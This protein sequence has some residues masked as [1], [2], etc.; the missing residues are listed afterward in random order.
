MA[1]LDHALSMKAKIIGIVGL[2]MGLMLM[3]VVVADRSMNTI[4]AEL[5]HISGE[6][7]HL[8]DAV[9]DITDWQLGEVAAFERVL[10]YAGAVESNPDVVAQSKHKAMTTFE[11]YDNKIRSRLVDSVKL[12][13]AA[14]ENARDDSMRL[15]F[16]KILTV[17]DQ[18]KLEHAAYI[19]NVKQI[20]ELVSAGKKEEALAMI[21]KVEASEHKIDGDLRRI[22]D[23]IDRFSTASTEMAA[24]QEASAKRTLL[25]A[26]IAALLIGFAISL[27]TIRSLSHGLSVAVQAV[28][29]V[30]SGDL[31]NTIDTQRNDEIGRLL[32]ALEEMRAN[33]HDMVGKVF[34]SASGLSAAAEEMT[35]INKETSNGVSQQEAKINEVA[36]AMNEMTATVKEVAQNAMGA[37]EA[38]QSADDSAKAGSRVVTD[39]I[40]V[41]QSLAN[42]VGRASDVINSLAEQ[43]D[44]ITTVL[45]VIKGISEQT[46]LLA[47]NAAI[48]AARAGE[49]GRGFA[50]VAD[51]VR[52][53]SVRTQQSTNEIEEMIARLQSGARAAIE[54]MAS[55]QERAQSG[56]EQAGQA[57]EAL[58]AI[59]G[60]VAV[61]RD[62][63]V[64]IASAAE[65]QSAVSEEINRNIVNISQ[66]SEQN[67]EGAQQ[68]TLTSN[69]VAKQAVSLQTL[70]QQFRT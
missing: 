51:E 68:T 62:M 53:L 21:P 12:T 29:T 38:A 47:L 7:M 54:A 45:E 57:G 66:V 65:E 16:N 64:Q 17:L 15:E 55:S 34:G 67:A 5:K 9:T 22:Q 35:L 31:R 20:F 63:N 50:V 52:T 30:A 13:K 49:H 3:A 8:A 25:I 18:I 1:N 37:A 24:K 69:E 46:N 26:T 44:A 58:Q 36:V 41:I 11:E 23:K 42:E 14:L 28:E 56:V 33:L 10:R 70:V 48:E 27:L 40:K 39:T 60:A 2:L 32:K 43:S 59:T 19:S 6:D 61:I 4:S